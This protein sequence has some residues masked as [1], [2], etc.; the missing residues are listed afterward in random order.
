MEMYSWNTAKDQRARQA[1]M[2]LEQDKVSH[3]L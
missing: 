1:Y 3:L 2:N